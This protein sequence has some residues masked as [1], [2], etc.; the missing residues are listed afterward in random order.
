[1]YAEPRDAQVSN[2]SRKE[3]PLSWMWKNEEFAKQRREASEGRKYSTC[4]GIEERLSM[5]IGKR[6]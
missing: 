4:T 3:G 5:V 1:M 2:G 6:P